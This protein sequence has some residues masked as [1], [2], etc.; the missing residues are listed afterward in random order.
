MYETEEVF[1]RD[2]F[3]II[4]QEKDRYIELHEMI[5]SYPSKLV[6]EIVIEKRPGSYPDF[7]SCRLYKINGN[8]K[9][10]QTGT[11]GTGDP[12]A[13][14]NNL[15]GYLIVGPPNSNRKLLDQSTLKKITDELFH[16]KFDEIVSYSSGSIF[17]QSIVEN[18]LFEYG[19]VTALEG[20]S[21]L[22]RKNANLCLA[23][24][25]FFIAVFPTLVPEGDLFDLQKDTR[26]YVF[27]KDFK[28]TS[29]FVH[30]KEENDKLF[31]DEKAI[32]PEV[33]K[34]LCYFI[35]HEA[36]DETDMSIKTQLA[37]ALDAFLLKSI[38]ITKSAPSK[39][40]S[41]TSMKA[42]L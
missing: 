19:K 26:P 23:F 9:L 7:K 1:V 39:K 33:A 34:K 35:Y 29:L 14:F 18:K 12:V 22:L 6:V 42:F 5:E 40:T 41:P 15:F 25:H 24:Y 30:Y 16:E 3:G 37:K 11:I 8:N 20:F 38:E 4:L 17:N 13:F 27:T 21:N 28:Q 2:S 36:I 32:N 10:E 31:V